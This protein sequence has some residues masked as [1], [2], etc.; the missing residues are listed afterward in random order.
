MDITNQQEYREA[1]K[2]HNGFIILKAGD[3][4]QGDF[5]QKI[6]AIVPNVKG[7]VISI[8]DDDGDTEEITLNVSIIAA[9]GKK[10]AFESTQVLEVLEGEIHLYTSDGASSSRTALQ[11][12]RDLAPGGLSVK[13]S[14]A[15]QELPLLIQSL[16]DVINPPPLKGKIILS[17]DNGDVFTDLISAR[18]YMLYFNPGL[19]ITDE[20]FDNGVYKF[21]VPSGSSLVLISYI[22]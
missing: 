6:L 16:I 3:T 11:M 2:M 9:F 12:V 7:S 17:D 15:L 14:N 5:I 8:T 20:T 13:E 18:N 21:N 22:H 10:T 1:Y 19:I 4:I